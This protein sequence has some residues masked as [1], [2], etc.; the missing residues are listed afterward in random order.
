MED[1]A[2]FD[3]GLRRVYAGVDKNAQDI[4]ARVFQKGDGV[5]ASFYQGLTGNVSSEEL[6]VKWAPCFA[7]KGPFNLRLQVSKV[8]VAWMEH[9]GDADVCDYKAADAIKQ[10][11]DDC[12]KSPDEL[13]KMF[14]D[15][16]DLT[17]TEATVVS[18][19]PQRRTLYVD[20]SSLIA[21][22]S[23]QRKWQM[24]CA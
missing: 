6:I 1:Y 18:L 4:T 22:S 12:L 3:E 17:S 2:K 5:E 10:D 20:V 7:S 19:G 24:I 23:S 13:T 8:H 16:M 14:F 15:G 21:Y 11:A 9:F